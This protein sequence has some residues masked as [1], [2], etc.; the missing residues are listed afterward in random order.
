MLITQPV[1]N[2]KDDSSELTVARS[3][4]VSHIHARLDWY[5]SRSRAGQKVTTTDARMLSSFR[6]RLETLPRG[7]QAPGVS[8]VDRRERWNENFLDLDSRCLLLLQILFR[9]GVHSNAVWQSPKWVSIRCCADL[10]T[11]FRA[12]LCSRWVLHVSSGNVRKVIVSYECG[13]FS[14]KAWRI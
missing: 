8:D 7:F 5:V 6:K 3:N 4:H 11:V 14:R 2:P 1:R 12:T 10:I 13:H 9:S